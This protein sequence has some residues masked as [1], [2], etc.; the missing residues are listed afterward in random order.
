MVL[1]FDIDSPQA[2]FAALKTLAL[3]L[4]DPGLLQDAEFDA[5]GALVKVAFAWQMRGNPTQAG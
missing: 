5:H 1:L 2:A 3:Y 4:E